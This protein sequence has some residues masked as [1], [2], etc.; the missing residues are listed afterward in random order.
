MNIA[1][2]KQ[3]ILSPTECVQINVFK[4]QCIIGIFNLTLILV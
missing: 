1:H 4:I 3:E 2:A